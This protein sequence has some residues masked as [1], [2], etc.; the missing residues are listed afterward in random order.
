[1][2]M[3]SAARLLMG[4]MLI[5]MGCVDKVDLSLPYDELPL[6]IDG[7]VTDED[8]PFTVKISRAFP[9]DG[10]Y[11]V[12]KGV[13]ASSVVISDNLG[14]NDVLSQFRD[15][16]NTVIPGSYVTNS[17][18]G[19]IGRTYQLKITLPDGTELESS[20]ELMRASGKVD[21]I[22]FEYVT[23]EN[24]GTGIEESGF[25]IYVNATLAPESKGRIRWIYDG[26]YKIFTNPAAIIV[27]NPP[28]PIACSVGCL[29]CICYVSEREGVPI[30]ANSNYAGADQ[31]AKVLIKY[32]PINN[33]TFNEK[34]RVEVR[35]LELSQEVFDFYS[36]IKGQ[37]QNASSLFQPPFFELKGNVHFV[38]SSDRV[39]GVFSA[40][41]VDSRHIYIYR[42]DVP[43]EMFYN[44][45]QGDCRAVVPN[46]VITEPA[47]WE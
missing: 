43:Y 15:D 11:Y 7:L 17:L 33:Y 24:K 27:G 29:C 28:A 6:I 30:L 12:P 16:S 19:V 38:S 1:M 39:V 41:A 2:T 47:F 14:N 36:A 45:I 25:N 21:S 20:P 3:K 37:T 42:G 46:S 32:L 10:N 18:K 26:T 35:Q 40:A 31:L 8:R 23:A 4:F 9:V 44:E 22:Y 13:V 5:W 34:Y